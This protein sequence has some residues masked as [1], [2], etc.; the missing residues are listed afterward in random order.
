MDPGTHT[1]VRPAY[2]ST[3]V[4]VEVLKPNSLISLELLQPNS[5]KRLLLRRLPPSWGSLWYIVPRGLGAAAGVPPVVSLPLGTAILPASSAQWL[6]PFHLEMSSGLRNQSERV[7]SIFWHSRGLLAQ[8]QIDKLSRDAGNFGTSTKF[9]QLLIL[10][11]RSWW[12]STFPSSDIVDGS[13]PTK[14]EQS[15]HTVL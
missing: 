12:G 6:H 4:S 1:P 15:G 8:N 14:L 2:T 5:S 7:L 3:W 9:S 13:E 10:R 11:S